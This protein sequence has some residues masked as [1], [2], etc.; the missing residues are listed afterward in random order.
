MPSSATSPE[1]DGVRRTHPAVHS[2]QRMTARPTDKETTMSRKEINPDESK[3]L[4]ESAAGDVQLTAEDLDAV[5][6][7]VEGEMSTEL[8]DTLGCCGG[9]TNKT[10]IPCGSI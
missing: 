7:G 10:C 4:P 8:L 1:R 2:A 5:A 9:W 6:G 3:K